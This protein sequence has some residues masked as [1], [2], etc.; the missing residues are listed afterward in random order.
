MVKT[1]LV[2]ALYDIERENFDRRSINDY[3]DWLEKTLLLNANFVVYIEDKLLPRLQTIINKY[4][5]H[6]RVSIYVSRLDQIPYYNYINKINEILQNETFIKNV[7]AYGSIRT[8]LALYPIVQYAKL[9]WV[10]NAIDKNP[11]NSEFFFWIDVGCSRFFDDVDVSEEWPCLE[12]WNEIITNKIIVQSTKLGNC[13]Y[14]IH[15][16]PEQL[17]KI[18]QLSDHAL[19]IG[20]LYGG[21][22]DNMLWFADSM[23]EVFINYLNNTI[24]NYDQNGMA[25]IWKK[26]PEKFA[27]YLNDERMT[28]KYLPLFKA[29]SNSNNN[30]NNIIII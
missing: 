24:I 21:T 29:L 2:T 5:L 15:E 12:K 22:K 8:K 9:Q 19:S 30:N 18:F 3:F 4:N 6:K 28:R 25:L 10:K 23:K 1:T 20:T 14:F 16:Y 17:W 27:V 7:K 26:Y 11:Y 13:E